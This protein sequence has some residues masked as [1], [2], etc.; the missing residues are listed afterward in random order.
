M[1][2]YLDVASC[3]LYDFNVP[4]VARKYQ[5]LFYERQCPDMINWQSAIWG[6]KGAATL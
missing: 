3:F 2:R 1:S 5:V 4:L 6:E